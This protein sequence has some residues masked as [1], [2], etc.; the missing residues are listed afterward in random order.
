MTV[1]NTSWHF[2]QRTGLSLERE[3]LPE[4]PPGWVRCRVLRFQ[5]SITELMMV[6]GLVDT[7]AEQDLEHYLGHEFVARVDSG[8]DESDRDLVG[9]RVVCAPRNPCGWCPS[10]RVGE[11]WNCA[12]PFRI[13]LDTMG[14]MGEWID[15]P[16][17]HLVVV[18]PQ[19]SDLD[20]CCAQPAASAVANVLHVGMRPGARVMILGQGTMGLLL[21]QA[22]RALGAHAVMTTAPRDMSRAISLELGAD[23]AYDPNDRHLSEAA[24]R[25]GATLVIDAA[26]GATGVGLAG[27]QTFEQAIA[28]VAPYGTVLEISDVLAPLAV[29]SE[30]RARAIRIVFGQMG[31]YYGA[32]PLTLGLM[33]DGR[34]QCRRIVT[35]EVDGLSALPSALEIMSDR[36]RS[37][38]IQVQVVLEQGTPQSTEQRMG[39]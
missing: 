34:V 13:G 10:C 32:Y 17:R 36:A 26:G 35:H 5:P 28:L 37:K 23:A 6:R 1:S 22:A 25:F 27:A 16:R 33:S 30:A 2:S 29:P 9:K 18:P 15:L 3:D 38:A 31:Y 7:V 4:L 14:G 24:E 8:A 21:V 19:V 11:P 12:H 39:R 20:A